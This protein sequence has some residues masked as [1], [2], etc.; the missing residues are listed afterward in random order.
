MRFDRTP[1]VTDEAAEADG[2]GRAV[3]VR[4]LR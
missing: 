4:R 2:G 3:F 1:G